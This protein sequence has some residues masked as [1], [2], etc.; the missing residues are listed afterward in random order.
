MK[1]A[2]TAS[3]TQL[4][5]DIDPRFGRAIQFLIVDSETNNAQVVENQQNL[6]L[7]QGAGIQAAQ[8][9]AAHDVDVLI[10]GNCGPK[11]FKVLSA[12]KIKVIT[13]AQG[14][15]DLV[16]ERYRNGELAYADEANVEG[17]WV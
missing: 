16:L 14:R 10:T 8:T 1:I 2:I 11:A 4:S 13:G 12:A 15:I 6:D 17:H 5:S 3:G 9:I 7:P